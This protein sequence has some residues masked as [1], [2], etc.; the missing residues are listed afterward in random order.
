MKYKSGDVLAVYLNTPTYEAG[1]I[2]QVI[3][4]D[5]IDQSYLVAHLQEVGLCDFNVPVIRERYAKWVKEEN[6]QVI[7]LNKPKPTRLTKL[8]ELYHRFKAKIQNYR[9]S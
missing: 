7:N 1:G 2:V 3:D 6:L 5:P 9:R 8:K 4:R